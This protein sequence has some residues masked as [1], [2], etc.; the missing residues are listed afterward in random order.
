MTLNIPPFKEGRK[1]LPSEE[2]QRGR[3]IASLRIHVE[4]LEEISHFQ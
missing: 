2:I 1:Q 4:Y 3:H